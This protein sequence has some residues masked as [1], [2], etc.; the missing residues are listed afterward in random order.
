MKKF[1]AEFRAFVLRGN[2]IDLA[3]GIIIGGAFSTVVNSLVNDIIMPP[4]GLLFGNTDFSDLFVVL[5]QGA[6]ALPPDATLEMASEV[7]AVTL[8]YG[9]FINNIITLLIVA[10]AI[11]LIIRWMNRL[12]ESF[13]KQKE[14]VPAPT[15]KP[16]PYCATSI[17]VQATR[18]PNCTSQLEGETA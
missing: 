6:E 9:Q 17:P 15:E 2:M 12:R 18:C 5:K 10:L 11:F 3:I 7:G 14:E 8:N 4:V 13:A 1:V 16:C